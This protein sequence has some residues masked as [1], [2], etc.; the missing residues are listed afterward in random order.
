MYDFCMRQD[1]L[2]PNYVLI[3]NN[4]SCATVSKLFVVDMFAQ[5]SVTVVFIQDIDVD[6]DIGM[7]MW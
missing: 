5:S 4:F 6:I 3:V 1:V 2:D 7:E